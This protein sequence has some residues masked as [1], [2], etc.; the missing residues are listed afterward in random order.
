MNFSGLEEG[1][2]RPMC[3]KMLTPCKYRQSQVVMMKH[4]IA[5]LREASCPL[6][7]QYP[8]DEVRDE[9]NTVLLEPGLDLVIGYLDRKDRLDILR[10][11]N[12]SAVPSKNLS[13][14]LTS[15]PCHFT[16]AE[17][18][19]SSR[20]VSLRKMFVKHMIQS[21]PETQKMLFSGPM[22][23]FCRRGNTE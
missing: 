14:L 5:R 19:I 21:N 18:S 23:T 17:S 13:D 15:A 3:V 9:N 16:A 7:Y 22:P 11:K 10:R 8:W 6:N 20:E 12:I 2:I 1:L 4:L